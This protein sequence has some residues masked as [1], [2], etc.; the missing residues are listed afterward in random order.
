MK[1]HAAW[2]TAG[3]GKLGTALIT[4][5][6]KQDLETGLYHPD[7]EKAKKAAKN[8]STK[9]LKKDDLAKLDYLVLALPADQ[10]LP[11]V[12]D[13]KKAGVQLEETVLINMATKQETAELRETYPELQ[14][15]SVKYIGHAES[16]RRDGSGLFITEETDEHLRDRFSRIGHVE[17]AAEETA[18]KVNQLATSQ[19]VLAAIKLEK[20]MEE[21]GWNDVYIKHALRSLFPEV[22]RAYA[23]GKLGRFGQK[24][25]EEMDK[26]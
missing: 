26:K 1:Q 4:Q 18:E 9:V 25:V 23:D 2:G 7:A 8:L 17:T 14:W 11:F 12:K 6:M 15:A 20:Q 19:A 3:I 21:E 22:I 24:I 5:W 10:I 16:L 13:L